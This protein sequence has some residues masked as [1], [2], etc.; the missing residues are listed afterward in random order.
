MIF[1]VVRTVSA[2][3]I[4]SHRRGRTEACFF[5]A[6]N[7]GSEAEAQ[8]SAW[9]FADLCQHHHAVHGM[10]YTVEQ[11]ADDHDPRRAPDE[12]MRRE[13]EGNER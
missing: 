13:Q 2:D 6:D 1:S 8:R 3:A 10:T 9:G 4:C 11:F 5:N 7:R 12:W